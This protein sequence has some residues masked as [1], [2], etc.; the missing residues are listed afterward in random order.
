MKQLRNQSGSIGVVA[1]VVVAVAI[2]G[3]VAFQFMGRTTNNDGTAT[4]ETTNLN[5]MKASDLRSTLVSK[6]VEHMMLTNMAVSDALDGAKSADASGAALYA[7]GNDIGAA[8]GSVYGKDAETTFNTVWKLHLDQFVN[9]AV[10]SSKGDAA[11]KT[12]ALEAIE[13]GYTKPISAFLAKANPNLPQTALETGFRDHVD[14][15][16]KM[17][18]LHVAGDYTA[19]QAE[20]KMSNEHIGELMSTLAGGIVKQYPDKFKD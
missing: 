5:T 12:A 6:G 17:I 15:T 20:L 1:I 16:A 8:V 3:L 7:N 14:M 19:E 18:D 10:A 11:G 13:T 2:I 4:A 9:Y